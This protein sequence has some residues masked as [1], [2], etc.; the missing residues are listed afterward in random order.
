MKIGIIILVMAIG[1]T[2]VILGKIT[3]TEMATFV[4]TLSTAIHIDDKEVP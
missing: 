4:G 2:F 3:P 1:T